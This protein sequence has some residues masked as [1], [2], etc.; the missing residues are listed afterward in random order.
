[1]RQKNTFNEEQKQE[2]RFHYAALYQLFSYAAA[3]DVEGN[4]IL[5]LRKR[6]NPTKDVSD[7]EY[8]SATFI[9]TI[10][11]YDHKFES[12]VIDNKLIILITNCGGVIGLN[13][14]ENYHIDLNDPKSIDAA[15]MVLKR[16]LIKGSKKSQ[17]NKFNSQS[18]VLTK[19]LIAVT[20]LTATLLIWGLLTWLSMT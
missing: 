19:V 17:N 20:S 2:H 18:R 6:W 5:Y 13:P 16:H 1:M 11:N 14:S 8:E 10:D 15:F 7:A 3:S 12:W 9:C 4:A